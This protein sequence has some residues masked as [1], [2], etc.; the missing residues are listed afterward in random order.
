[1][2]DPEPL[3]SVQVIHQLD[4]HVPTPLL[5]TTVASMLPNPGKLGPSTCSSPAQ[6]VPSK[7]GPPAPVPPMAGMGS[8]GAHQ[9]AN[10]EHG[11]NITKYTMAL[12]NTLVSGSSGNV[13]F[14]R[15]ITPN[16]GRGAR[17]TYTT[18]CDKVGRGECGC[19]R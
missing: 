2:V 7:L 13:A 15:S 5:L 9:W 17:N 1:M 4:S 6:H 18:D 10:H 11:S 16:I 3:W 14:S 12:G 8:S 19:T